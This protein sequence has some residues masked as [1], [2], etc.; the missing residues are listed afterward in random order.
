MVITEVISSP[1]L[2]I[3]LHDFAAVDL[4]RK[5][6]V[7]TA[8]CTPSAAIALTASRFGNI[9]P[10]LVIRLDKAIEVRSEPVHKTNAPTFRFAAQLSYAFTELQSLSEKELQVE[11]WDGAEVIG[12]CAVDLLS[13]A[14]GAAEMQ[15]LSLVDVRAPCSTHRHRRA[16]VVRADVR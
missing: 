3:H 8:T 10:Y 16:A 6:Y 2:D 5:T 1:F 14:T 11:L 9:D 12:Q 4:P 13:L 15:Q 7:S